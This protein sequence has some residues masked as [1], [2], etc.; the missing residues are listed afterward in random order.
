MTKHT[1]LALLCAVIVL[2]LLIPPALAVGTAPGTP[3]EY[4]LPGG[5]E[6]PSID[7]DMVVFERSLL[8]GPKDIYCM[9]TSG[10]GLRPITN[11]NVPQERPSISGDYV[12][13]QE[14]RNGNWDIYLYSFS[15]D[16][17]LQLTDSP[18]DQ[19][20]PVIH[21]NYVVWYDNRGGSTDICLYD[22]SAKKEKGMIGCNPELG[23]DTTKFKPALSDDYVSWEEVGSGLRLYEIATGT[24]RTV[25]SSSMPQ[26]WPSIAGDLI[27][28]EDYRWGAAWQSAIY[29]KDLSTGSER[30]LTTLSAEQVS[31]ALSGS[32]IAWEDKRDGQWSIYMY[33]LADLPGGEEM[34]VP[35]AGGEQ[36][37]P[38]VSGNTIVW[39]KNRGDFANICIYTYV[40]DEPVQIVTRIEVEPSTTVMEIGEE[41]KFNATCY[42]QDDNAMP[43]LKVTWACSNATVGFIDPGGYFLASAAGIATITASTAGVS[44]QATVIVDAPEQILTTVEI[45]PST[46]TVAVGTTREFAVACYDQSGNLMTGVPVAWASSNTTVGTVNESGTFTALAEGTADLTATAGGLSATAAVTVI[47]PASPVLTGI[48]VAPATAT[49]ETGETLAFTATALDQFGTAMSGVPITWASGNETVGTIDAAGTFTARAVG[50]TTVT[51]SAG[52]VTGTATVTVAAEAPVAASITVAPAAATLAVN[53]HQQFIA[54]VLDQFGNELP[55]P[56]VTWTS[57]NGTVGT[58]STDGIFTALAAGTATVTASAGGVAG[59]ATVSVA[60]DEQPIGLVAVSPSAVTLGIADARQFEAIVFDRAGRIVPDAEVLWASSDEAVGTVGADGIFTALAAGTTAVTASVDGVTG[61]AAVTVRDD[62][63]ALAS[64]SIAPSAITLAAGETE[65]FVATGYDQ[66]GRVMP[67][68]G[69]IWACSDADVG[70]IGADGTFVALAAGTATVTASADGVTGT[71]AVTVVSLAPGLVVSPAAIALDAGASRQFIATLYDPEGNEMPVAEVIWSCN[72]PAVGTIN[73]AGFFTAAGEGTATV[74]ALVEE[75]GETGTATVTVRPVL[76]APGRI[77]VSPS[78]LTIAAGNSV[79]LT[80]TVFD[81]DGNVVADPGIAW[82]CDD[83]NVGTIGADGVFTALAAGTATVTAS[84]GGISGIA[85]VTV[86]PSFS[87]PACIEV[88]PASATLKPGESRAFIAT[89]FDQCDDEMDWVRVAW[90]CSNPQ[91]G[92]IDRNGLFTA[93]AEGTATVKASIGSVE[94]TVAVTVAGGS[95]PGGSSGS[96]RGSGGSSRPTFDA[97]TCENL[98][99]G[100]TFTFSGIA[101]SSVDSVSVTASGTIPRLMLTV[102]GAGSPSGAQPPAGE[103]FEY[104]EITLNWANPQDV[105]SA[106]V[107]FTIP[108]AWLEAH[109]MAPE[110]VVLMRCVNGEWQSLETEVIGEGNGNYRF[111][112]TTPGFSTFAIV[113]APVNATPTEEPVPTVTEEPNVTVTETGNVT[114]EATPETTAVPTTAPAAPLVYAPFLAPLAFLLWARRKN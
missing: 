55:G 53:D 60:A 98:R 91:V 19:W 72:D 66:S 51:A 102:K 54:T 17:T 7:G 74:T 92:T 107:A 29:L 79:A 38:A 112:A 6:H 109:G 27:A 9:S 14:N 111:R 100:E 65:R 48:E 64:I 31:P 50:T 46:A 28:W 20:L 47:A 76:P 81:P 108:A 33:D 5:Q 82:S 75:T 49:V 40:A 61:T 12:V 37:Y 32:I 86:E 44:A 43:D 95:T 1:H 71:A 69:V 94:R 110:D 62:A 26:S 58:I 45:A 16:E 34:S 4:V 93:V 68:V 56:A 24:K 105:S 73:T 87:V 57:S 30:Q 63:P 22:I 78:D 25:S 35:T 80:A 2:G 97:G 83:E 59:T 90:S 41:F 84:A 3:R 23:T 39:Q 114:E 15:K 77:V 10:T 85:C 18:A 103:I 99:N 96:S 101:T 52:G 106:T 8:N 21:G 42:D 67:D 11:D 89:V 13:W 113:A 70:M 36:I 88:A 104:V